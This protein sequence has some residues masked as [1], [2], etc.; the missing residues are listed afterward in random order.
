MAA[1]LHAQ[2][3]PPPIIDSISPSG[4]TA[5]SPA[6]TMQITGS[7]Y[8]TDSRVIWRY[9]SLGALQLQT[10]YISPTR[11]DAAVPGNLLSDS[12]N[13][14]I[15]VQQA[16]DTGTVVSNTVVFVIFPGLTITTSCPL[17]NAIVGQPYSTAM[18]L[19]GGTP[20]YNWTLSGGSLPPGLSLTTQGTVVGNAATATP[21]NFILRVSDAQG[22]VAT[23][24]CSMRSVSGTQNQT[25]FITALSPSG[26]LAGASQIQLSIR[27]TGFST[28]TTA[29]WNFGRAGATDLATTFND[30]TLLTAVIPAGFLVNP[31]TYPVAV[32]QQVLTQSVFSNAEDFV[33]SAPVSVNSQCPLRDGTLGQPYSETLSASGGFTPYT[34][35][36]SEGAAPTG[37]AVQRS[38]TLSGTPSEAG[39]FRFTLSV[40]DSRGNPGTKACSMRVLGPL[41]AAPTALTFT[42]DASGAV[43]PAQGLS[44]AAAFADAGITS[45]AFTDT[46]FNWLRVSAGDKAPA[47][48]RVTVDTGSLG[49]GTYRGQITVTSDSASN[50]SVAVPVTLVINNA[51][52]PQ[53]VPLP[54]SVRFLAPREGARVPGQ[55][56]ALVNPN[57]QV[58]PFS[59]SVSTSTGGN[60]LTVT[61][62]L[63]SVSA[64]NP[65]DLQVRA[66]ASDL[67]AGTY[68]G[69]IQ[70]ASVGGELTTVPVALTV[71]QSQELMVIPQSNITVQ[72]TAGGPSPSPKRIDVVTQGPNGFFWEATSS[73]ITWLNA[74]P[75]SDFSR[76]GLPQYT[77]AKIDSRGLDAGLAFG[78]III[79]TPSADNSPRR[80]GVTAQ[81]LAS[82]APL[83]PE[84]SDTALV[85]RGASPGTQSFTIR[86]MSRDNITAD[87]QFTGDSRVFTVTPEPERSVLVGLTRKITVAVNNPGGAGGVFRGSVAVRASNSTQVRLVDLVYAAPPASAR[88]TPASFVVAA[89]SLAAGYT[90]TSGLP[91]TIEARV[92]DNCGEPVTS[93]LVTAFAGSP[94]VPIQLLH[95]A[96]GRWVG[97]WLVPQMEPGAVSVRIVAEDPARNLQGFTAI[98]GR[99]EAIPFF[100]ALTNEGVLSASSL[101][102]NAPLSPGS[103]ISLFGGGMAAGRN[104]ANSVPFPFS[105]GST[106]VTI[107]GRDIPIFFAGD[108]GAFTQVNGIVPSDL[109]PNNVYQLAVIRDGRRSQYIDVTLAPAAPGVFTAT[110]TGSGQAIVVNGDNQAQLA[111]PVNPAP[112]GSVVVIYCEGLGPVNPLTPAGT[113]SPSPPAVT[114]LPVEVTIG[115][116]P[117]TV[118]FSGLTPGAVSLYQINAIV[119]DT[120]APS[121]AVPL[122]ISA[123]G[124][125]S[126]AVT[127]AVR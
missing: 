29:V 55:V 59:I 118:L 126:R 34:W 104:A 82:N 32:R 114:T 30:P 5:N 36:I 2:A 24:D 38:G 17:A 74:D 50:R 66:N 51:R 116:V 10:T 81:V 76:L 58:R 115:G 68:R 25:L 56:L 41:T 77:E 72:A 85:F 93:G 47:L 69:S 125:P 13:I 83:Q 21:A 90:V 52:T 100:P 111:D 124:Q 67:Q 123:G 96:D 92:F 57:T 8:R 101:L 16:G 15:V 22:N 43:P 121:S 64:N 94:E 37:L 122:V 46:S 71:T 63:G 88:C 102:A 70:I 62:A 48:L 110:Q 75:P 54:A 105:L 99:S 33:V 61:P 80:V 28:A 60:W 26:V 65:V 95:V 39:S 40:T 89:S 79:A 4:L 12:G 119:P 11:I 112:R 91:A 109:L 19:I 117:A 14:N 120:A 31:G 113:R 106:R 44:V 53:I 78:D 49:P 108:Q 7:R 45:Q 103:M 9:G 18:S 73:V 6:F 98:P 107:G 97:T 23:K 35:T 84:L 1:S 3:L 127:I 42:A 87:I 20:P 27:G 86:N